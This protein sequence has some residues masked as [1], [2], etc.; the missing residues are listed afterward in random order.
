M[1]ILM[2]WRMRAAACTLF[3]SGPCVANL[4][5]DSQTALELRNF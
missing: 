2:D 4:I 1:A 3:V 5:E